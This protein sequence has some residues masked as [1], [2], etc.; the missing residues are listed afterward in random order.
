MDRRWHL[1]RKRTEEAALGCGKSLSREKTVWLALNKSLGFLVQREARARLKLV[2]EA[3]WRP[4]VQGRGLKL[5][6]LWLSPS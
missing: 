6:S 5:K 3:L 1:H 2:W 4:P